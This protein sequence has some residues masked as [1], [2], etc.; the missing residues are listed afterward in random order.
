MATGLAAGTYTC[1]I[2]DANG[3]I[4][5]ETV[6]VTQPSQLSATALSTPVSCNGGTNGT[7]TATPNGGTAGYTYSWSP[8]GG[9]GAMATGLSSGNYTVIITD[10]NGCTATQTISVTQPTPLSVSTNGNSVCVGSS[11]IISANSTGGAGSYT[12]LWSN[13]AT[14]ASQTVSPVTT[15]GYSVT[16]TDANGCSTTGTVTLTVNPQPT[17]AI[18]SNADNGV[19]G[20]SGATG[21]LCFFGPS[22]VAGW[23]WNLNGTD[24]SSQQSPC[25]TVTSA[26]TGQYCASL[27]VVNTSGC[28]DTAVVCVDIVNSFFMI[29][30]VFTPNNDGSNDVFMITNSGMK[31]LRCQIFNRW[32]ELVYEWDGTTGSWDGKARNGNYASDGV[33]YYTA[34][35]VDFS[36]KVYDQSGFVHLISGN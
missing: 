18:G 22:N 13:G 26:D 14:T 28:F 36:D 21:Q 15:T 17:A 7:A 2:T 32:G 24:T 31:S 25:I 35:L 30:N 8:S 6:S 27:I 33:Y 10:A 34:H 19:F 3:C 11:G 12:Y 20:L 23:Y 29:P 5:T 9:S 16:V 1:T 4:T